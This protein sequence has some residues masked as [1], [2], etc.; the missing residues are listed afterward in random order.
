MI[1]VGLT[2]G[3]A[4]GKSTVSRTLKEEK[5][6]IVDAD[7]IVHDLLHSNTQVIDS[8]IE[9]FGK[10][11]LDPSGS[12]DR[13]QLGDIVFR[14][15]KQRL[16]LNRIVHPHV[17]E[18]AESKKKNI[19]KKHPN[20][21]IVFDA[22]LLIET[23]AH[24]KMDW[25]LLAYVDPATQISRLMHRDRLSKDEA[26]LK[27]KAQIPIDEKIPWADE[28]IDCRKPLQDLKVDV[29]RIYLRLQKRAQSNLL[30]Q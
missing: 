13:K 4:S 8:I 29:H 17:F 18:K 12:I 15:E 11:V 19:I 30:G 5:A 3:I 20:A 22:A 9:V 23:K 26:I 24:Q 1:W 6:F 28:V 7:R 10:E 14:N 21:V 25:V 16:L 2:G 27:I